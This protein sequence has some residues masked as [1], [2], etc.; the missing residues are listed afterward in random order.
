MFLCWVVDKLTLSR[1][2]D[3]SLIVTFYIFTLPPNCKRVGIPT[4][5]REVTRGISNSIYP[6][7]EQADSDIID[8]LRD[9]GFSTCSLLP[10]LWRRSSK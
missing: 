6:V 4:L 10:S 9:N 1:R 7:R 3:L 2:D 5:P 8:E